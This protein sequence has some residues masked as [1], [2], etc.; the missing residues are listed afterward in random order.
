LAPDLLSPSDSG[1]WVHRYSAP[2]DGWVL[3]I[4]THAGPGSRKMSLGG[5]RIATPER[6]SLP[7][8]DNDREAIGLAVG[9]EEKIYWSRL[10][11]VG[12]PLALRD[13]ARIV[14]GK[15]VLRPT[16][17]ARVGEPHDRALLDFAVAAF[18]DFE[19]TAGAYLTTG[20]D[21]GHGILSDGATSSLR[22]VHDRFKGSVLSDTSKPTAEGNYHLLHGVLR[23]LGI[24]LGEAR[25]ALIGCGNIGEH[26][27][28]RLR[29]AGAD[30]VV[31]EVMPAKRESLSRRGIAVWS[32][33]N[34]EEFLQR[35]V[36]AVVVN[37]AGGS[38]DPFAVELLSRNASVRVICGCENLA[39]PDPRG[40]EVL[41]AARKIYCPTELGGMMGYLTAVEEYLAHLEGIPFD[42]GSLFEAA[43][44]LEVA[45]FRAA[46]LVVRRD[47]TMSFEDAV[48]EVFGGEGSGNGGQ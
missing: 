25:V 37:A 11:R 1:V 45:G 9:M 23:A 16:D 8:Y 44:R 27:L 46:A 15:C 19:A 5:F 6:T 43:Q 38:L 30:V 13:S 7:G 39:M 20:Q 4:A 14:G 48:R 12:G 18:R 24:G 34:R 29:A 17:G 22:Y 32:P 2:D 31:M 21:L 26:V 47:H 28:G 10:I 41:R 35:P 40:A 42:A 36:D 3:S 33:E